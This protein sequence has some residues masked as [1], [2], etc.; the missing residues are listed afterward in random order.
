MLDKNLSISIKGLATIAGAALLASTALV[1]AETYQAATWLP[2]THPLTP[3]PYEQFSE[4]VREAT[5]GEIDFEVYVGGSLIPAK[6]SLKGVADGIA[7]MGFVTGA[8]TPADLPLDNVLN[9]AAITS[10]D[11]LAAGFAKTQMAM[12]HPQ[13]QA[14]WTKNGVVYGGGFSTPVYN[15]ICAKP[16]KT[17]AD[18]SGLKVRTAGGSH[19]AWVKHFGGTPISVP[20]GEVYTGLQLGTLDCTLGDPTFMTGSFNLTEVAKG[21]TKLPMGTHI[22][23]A[24]WVYNPSFWRGLTDEQRRTLLDL[25]AGAQVETLMNY[26]RDAMAAYDEAAAVG[27]EVRDA[28]ASLNE[29]FADFKSDY[30][31]DLPEISVEVRGVEDPSQVIEQFLAVQSKWKEILATIDRTDADA[32]TEVVK[33]HIY[34]E[35]DVSSYGH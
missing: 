12:T 29:A 17:A 34:D 32:V 33:K 9:D 27:V 22:S 1:H 8:Y 5:G 3:R 4:E 20:A 18:L 24:M 14:E 13:L 28:D 26:E 7:S 15:F 23:G 2:Q 30:L 11:I 25:M 35:I 6:G 16:V 31:T 19:V 10:D 21:L